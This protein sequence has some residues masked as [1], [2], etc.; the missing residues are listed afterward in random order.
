MFETAHSSA[1]ILAVDDNQTNLLLY[2]ELLE[3]NFV[4]QTAENGEQ[5]LEM[6]KDF[7]PDIILLDIMMT[8]IS[9]YEVC[10][11]IRKNPKYSSIKVVLV[12]AKNTTADRIKGYEVGAD[13]YLIKPFDD[14]ELQA[15][16]NVFLRLKSMEEVDQ[17]KT[18]VMALFSHETRTPL[19]GILGPLELLQK[20]NQTYS[21]E[22]RQKWFDIM[23]TSAQRLQSLIERAMLLSNLRSG[24]QTLSKKSIHSDELLQRIQHASQN[25]DS[26]NNNTLIVES[27]G[28]T[29]LEID[30]EL[31]QQSLL[32]VVD[33]AMKFT[34]ENETVK[35]ITSMTNTHFKIA[36]QDRGPGISPE[37]IDHL[38]DSFSRIHDSSS[39]DGQSLSLPIAYEVVNLHGGNIQADNN[40]DGGSTVELSLPLAA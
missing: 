22:D 36:V 40:P 19:N 35:L 1:K 39:A 14:D 17:L 27:N 12:S 20:N 25:L 6:L 30:E 13:D 3:D 34:P 8:G 38:F 23:S 16:I 21:A 4:L 26:T 29:E 31:I 37:T 7:T 9:G 28:A 5:A 11:E 24:A 32:S 2:T 18:G 33:N 15:K 10:S